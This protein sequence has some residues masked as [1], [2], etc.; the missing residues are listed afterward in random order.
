MDTKYNDMQI[1]GVPKKGNSKKV[2]KIPTVFMVMLKLMAY[3]LVKF[4]HSTIKYTFSG[5]Y[6]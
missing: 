5:S 3:F 2:K 6:I 4:I 1:P